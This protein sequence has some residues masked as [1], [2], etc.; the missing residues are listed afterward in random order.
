MKKI[1]IS[2]YALL[3]ATFVMAYDFSVNGIFYNILEDNAVAV[4]YND[5]K[6]M[7]FY[8]PQNEKYGILV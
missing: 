5:E 3:C 6:M 8:R 1:I 4:T 2:I 7:E